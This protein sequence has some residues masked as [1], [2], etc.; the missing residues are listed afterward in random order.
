MTRFVDEYLPSC[1]IGYPVYASPRF[2]T[3][4]ATVDSGREDA[5]QRWE[6]ALSRYSIPEAVRD[7][8]TFN[9]VRTH[10]LVMRG[11][12]KL[13]PFRDPFD[14]ASVDLDEPNIE[15]IISALDQP[16]GTGDGVTSEFQIVKNYVAGSETY[17]RE[18]YLPIVSSVLVAIDGA[19]TTAFSVDR[20][21]GVITFDSPPDPGD[22]LTCGFLFDVSVRF[23]SDD[24]FDAICQ[25]FG[26]G[27]FADMTLL[28]S[29]IC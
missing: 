22:E 8:T 29:R 1:V 18:I 19:T 5:N 14:F 10:W 28:E 17:S 25:S 13:W 20:V 26:L 24:S 12:A 4:I 21:S 6:N 23:E 15:P 16:L 3:D 27:G 11:P 9:A 7:M 2:S